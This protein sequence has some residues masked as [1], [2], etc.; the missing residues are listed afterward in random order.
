MSLGACSR[1]THD[2]GSLDCGHV[3]YEIHRQRFW[4]EGGNTRTPHKDKVLFIVSSRDVVDQL[5]APRRQP[6]NQRVWRAQRMCRAGCQPSIQPSKTEEI[7][8]FLLTK[9]GSRCLK[10]S[11]GFHSARWVV[12]PSLALQRAR[13]FFLARLQLDL[14]LG[15]LDEKRE[16]L[17][18]K[19]G[20]YTDIHIC[21]PSYTPYLPRCRAC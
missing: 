12:A 21:Q 20:V 5:S 14:T 15:D 8:R 7:F 1:Y 13:R 3:G 19:N 6:P 11:L 2:V 16:H 10:L 9:T 17:P 18:T 4:T